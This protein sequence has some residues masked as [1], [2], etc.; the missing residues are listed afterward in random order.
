MEYSVNPRSSKSIFYANPHSNIFISYLNPRKSINNML[1]RFNSIWAACGLHSIWNFIPN[2]ILGLNLSVNDT[3]TSA[4]FD[5]RSTGSNILN[6]GM[7]G[8]EA[9]EVTAVILSVAVVVC[10]VAFRKGKVVP[11][12]AVLAS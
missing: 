10:Y 11:S 7:Y 5:I 3:M 1:L 6:G 8:I 12:K 4:V 9:S 2:N